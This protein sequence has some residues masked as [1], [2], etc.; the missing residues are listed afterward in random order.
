MDYDTLA[1][2]TSLETTVAALTAHNFEPEIIN[3][4]E[5]ALER[6]KALIPTG[7]SVMNGASR[8]LDEIGFVGHLQSGDHDWHNLHEAILSEKDP[9]AQQKLRRMSV[10]SDFYLGSVHALSETGEMVIASNTGSQLPHL[11]YTSP[12]IILVVSTKKITPTLQDALKRLEEHVIPL[13]DERLLKAH[14]I[15]TTHAKTLIMHR[16]NPNMGRHIHVLLVKENLG[17]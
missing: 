6:I 9:A 16:E 11:V 17:F 8:T 13:E 3:T 10:V 5:E 12:N 4:K 15:H 14:G 7:A 2:D 1:S